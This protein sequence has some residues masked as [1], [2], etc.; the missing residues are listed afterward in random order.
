MK[1]QQHVFFSHYR[2][3]IGGNEGEVQISA[4]L[5]TASD[6]LDWYFNV[7][8]NILEYKVA[9]IKDTRKKRADLGVVDTDV[10]NQRVTPQ[11]YQLIKIFTKLS[12]RSIENYNKM[13]YRRVFL[14]A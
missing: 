9:N 10:L 1:L 12:S 6:N 3:D 8:S 11:I 14:K 4:P 5:T 7:S 13:C 2:V